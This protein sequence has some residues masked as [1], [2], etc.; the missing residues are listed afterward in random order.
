MNLKFLLFHCRFPLQFLW[1]IF[2][3][4][5]WL[6]QLPIQ[7]FTTTNS[8]AAIPNSSELS[9]QQLSQ[10]A[11]SIT[12]KV[13][14]GQTSGSGIIIRRE[15]QIYTVVTNEHVLLPGSG[16]PYRIQTPDGRFYLANVSREIGFDENDLGVLQFR[17][18]GAIYAVASLGNSATVA[19][20]DDIFAA[21]FPFS[22]K[23]FVFTTGKISLVLDKALEGGYQ[24]GYTND[25]EKG[26]SGGPLLNR[27][28]KLVGINGKHAYPIWGDGYLFQ[29]GSL[30]EASLQ[31][32]LIRLSWAVP[33]ETFAQQ[34]GELVFPNFTRSHEVPQSDLI[35]PKSPSILP[36]NGWLW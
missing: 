34:A 14:A 7:G 4:G 36:A 23:G 22:I 33:I 28:G 16:K 10:L 3:I 25:I 15:G 31:A 17:S 8:A 27:Q 1:L 5:S 30:P 2:C 9:L 24:I 21:G 6:I 29:D 13:F 26:M 32:Q 19:Q 11:Q 18:E 35:E 20:G 12:V